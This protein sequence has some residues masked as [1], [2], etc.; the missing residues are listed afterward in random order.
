MKIGTT[1]K[2]KFKRLHRRLGFRFVRETVGLLECLWA[3]TAR[4]APDGAIGRAF[5]NEDIA[6]ELEWDG[7]PEEL[8]KIL[9]ET[10]WLDE[11]STPGGDRLLVHDWAEHAPNFLKAN[12]KRHGKTFAGD[13]ENNFAK[14]APKEPTKQPTKQAPLAPSLEPSSGTLPDEATTNP[15][16]SNPIQAN[17]HLNPPA[18]RTPIE[19]IQAVVDWMPATACSNAKIFHDSFE[20]GLRQQGAKVER[21]HKCPDRGDGRPGRID[22]LVT[23][24]VRF[25][26][27]LDNINP[28]IKSAEKL[29][30]LDCVGWV[31]TRSPLEIH[32]LD[33]ISRP[34]SG[35][36]K[37]DPMQFPVPE[38]LDTQPFWD[39]WANWA[40]DRRER[41]KS[42][43]AQAAKLQIKMLAGEEREHGSGTAVRVIERS[44]QNQW[45]GLF[46]LK[47]E[48]AP[49]DTT[50]RIDE[51]WD[52]HTPNPPSTI[53]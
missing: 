9:T 22:I 34:Q 7:D 46:P 45:T 30:S 47:G 2:I 49:K 39:A 3:T 27:E 50:G 26:L 29:R 8:V 1:E 4:S 36:L 13:P 28:R 53:Y 18:G 31:I 44:I 37:F 48:D 42:L 16:L 6:G 32:T 5:S 17:T 11:D 24:P 19:I 43:T 14:Q 51:Q 15:I 25:A 20:E 41:G 12:F 10:R 38:I 52:T 23:H 40:N 35:N 21:E 33:S